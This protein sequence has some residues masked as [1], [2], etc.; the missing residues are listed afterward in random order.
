MADSEPGLCILEF[1]REILHDE[2]RALDALAD[3]LGEAFEKA[4]HLILECRGKLIVSGL[5]KSGHVGRKIAATFASTGTTATFLHLAEAIHG[6]LGMAAKGDV[7]IL[8]SQSGET[9][10]L[11]PVI[12]HFE[13]VGLPIIAITGNAGSMLAEAATAPLLLPHWREVGPEAVAP[14][15]STT[16]T[17]ALGDA[18]AMTVMRQ[19][20][21]TRADFG[22]LHPGGS[23][24]ARLKPVGKLMHKGKGLPLTAADSNMHDTVVEMTARR[25]GVIGVTDEAGYLIGVI[26]DGD[27]RRNIERGL[28]HKAAEFMTRDPKTITPDSLVDE[29]ITLFEEHKIT[30]LFVVDEDG[31]GKKPVGV[32]HIHDCPPVR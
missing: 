16:M 7:A 28:D 26:T 18:L 17:L 24:G 11:E 19:K 9:V 32:L 6:D 29:A 10:E 23:L 4:V 14:T 15:T 25:L 13:R 8:I 27:L 12:D 3:S 20:G 1:G 2:A 22:R 31:R 5:G 30:A 21:F